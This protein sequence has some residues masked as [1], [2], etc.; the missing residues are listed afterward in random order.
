M[1]SQVDKEKEIRQRAESKVLDMEIKKSELI[2]D[3]S[4]L[5][6]QNASLQTQLNA[7]KEKVFLL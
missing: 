4:Q 2:V 3:N 5:R 7:E 1:K 6:Q